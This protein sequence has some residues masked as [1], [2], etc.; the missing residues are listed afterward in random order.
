MSA[1]LFLCLSCTI[2]AQDTTP[3]IDSLRSITVTGVRGAVLLRETPIAITTVSE[4]K[5][6]CTI[7]PNIIDALIQHVPG[8][9]AVK[10]GPNISKPVIR[11]LGYNRV[12]TLYDGIRQ[13]GQQWGDEH[14]IEVD[15]YGI[16]RAEVIK[17]PASLLYGSD[18]L[19]GV[20]S[21]FPFRPTEKDGHLHGRW[22]QE[23]QGNNGLI[24]N[25]LR[26]NYSDTKWWWTAK[27]SYRI[28][29]NYSNPVDGPVYNT[30]FRETNAALEGGRELPDG[31]F[32]LHVTAYDNLQGIPDG[33]RDSLTR[34][35]TR[36]IYEAG[37]DTL[38]LRPIVPDPVL[39]SYA[40]SPLHQHIQHYRLY[41]TIKKSR[42]ETLLGLQQNIRREYNHP[43]RPQQAGLY[44]RLNTLNY[45]F[46]YMAPQWRNLDITAGINGMY[47]ANSNQ[48]GTDFPIPDYHLSDGGAYAYGK[49]K[50]QFL[51][52]SG[53]LRYDFRH[54]SIPPNHQFTPLE[55]TY[56]GLSSSLGLT[57][58]ATSTLTVRANASSGYRSPGITEIASNG[59]DPGAHIT[60]LGNR[61]FVPELSWQEDLGFDNKTRNWDLSLSLFNNHIGHYIYLAQ[62]ADPAGNPVVDA[63][64][65]K[66]FQY[67]QSSAHLYGL[68]A[69]TALHPESLSGFNLASTFTLVYGVNHAEKYAHTGIDGEFLPFIPPLRWT[70]DLELP[71][72]PRFLLNRLP[73]QILLNLGLEYNAAQHRYLA[74]YNTETPTP[75]YTL[76]HAGANTTIRLSKT[77]TIQW[78]VQ[79]ENLLNAAFQSNL[80]RL[81]YFEYYTRSPN[82]RPGIYNMG[83][84]I[85]T[86]ITIPF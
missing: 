38:D 43:T 24:G 30:G 13:E 18:A 37:Q 53:G 8:L 4:K 44:V 59:L 7:E 28:A 45:G 16:E 70:G 65:N 58:Q 81:K 61:N 77:L 21:L 48:D 80:S 60:Y 11:G 56:T 14:G 33:S 75:S 51:T 74:L 1:I 84:S 82:G 9:S 17:G 57:W 31:F 47:Q 12:L 86:R 42:T 69:S 34:R 32:Q 5:L 29:K 15:A 6:T 39:N 26:L 62:L 66:T 67:Q 63:Q 46:K 25:A 27:A 78:L 79:I 40:L 54:L 22:L 71:L 3:K 49:W 20:V 50:H 85:N 35:F 73:H 23:Y 64:G 83:R 55:K 72:I 2:Q 52:I 41:T 76:F 19:G 36:Q 10:T 68:E